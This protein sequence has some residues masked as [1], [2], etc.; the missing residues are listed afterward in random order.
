MAEI[1]SGPTPAAIRQALEHILKAAEFNSSERNRRF[2]HYVVEETLAGRAQGIKAYN[3]ATTVFG[4][5]GCFDPQLN[6]IVRIEA[7]RLRRSLERYYLTG[8]RYDPVRIDIPKG[9]YVPVFEER[10]TEPPDSAAAAPRRAESRPDLMVVPFDEEGDS[11]GSPGF[12]RGFVRA[13]VVALT[14][15]TTLR[16][17]DAETGDLPHATEQALRPARHGDYILS[18]GTTLE[19]DQV[20]V[21]VLLS[22]AATGRVIWGDSL[23]RIYQRSE[24]VAVRNG[25][26]NQIARTIAQPYGII[27]TDYARE[28]GT[29]PNSPDGAECVLRFYR[30]WRTFD[31]EQLESVRDCL[32]RTIVEAPGDA[33]AYACLSLVNATVRRFAHLR[34]G[35]VDSEGA[36]VLALARQAVALAPA[37]SLARYALG[38]AFW[39]NGDIDRSL[40]ALE[41]ALALNPNDTT[42]MADLGQHYALLAE[43]DRAV[44]LLREAFARNPALPGIFHLGMFLFHYAHGRFDEALA[45]AR[46]VAADSV[47][48]GWIG[49]AAAAA[50]LG[51]KGEAKAAVDAILAIDPEYGAQVASDLQ[52]RH[53][54]P[55]L[56]ISVTEGLQLAGLSGVQVSSRP[57]IDRAGLHADRYS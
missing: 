39:F 42:V 8:G 5:D 54:E 28:V 15:F 22:D 21:D 13:L 7:G 2:L 44:P 25:L 24:L 53:L 20:E 6:S 49:I 50:R 29:R 12:T 45:A 27:H 33:E 17:F 31:Q 10:L 32:E 3:I 55:G 40:E 41:G 37:S 9:R 18:G 47:V 34:A 1:G 19:A 38:I 46:R 48:Y 56:L 57:K 51:N 14:R 52:Q 4:R 26:A 35:E 43:W 11:A 23:R 36:Q 30:Y 16:V